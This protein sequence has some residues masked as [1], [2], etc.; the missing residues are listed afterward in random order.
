MKQRQ[1]PEERASARARRT[2]EDAEQQELRRRAKREQW[3]REGMYL[4]RDEFEA[5]EPCRG[6]GQALLD[7]LPELPG[8][9]LGRTPEQQ[10]EWDQE[11]AAFTER[12]PD[13]HA[14]IWSMQGSRTLHCFLCCPPVPLSDEQIEGLRRLVGGPPPHPSSLNVWELSLTC[15]HTSRRRQ[16]RD[17]QRAAWGTD[18]C[19]TCGVVRGVIIAT[20]IGPADEVECGE[21]AARKAQRA[22]KRSD[23]PSKAALRRRLREA[24]AQAEA[25]RVQLAQLDED[26]GPD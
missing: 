10:S 19:A 13:C 16:H 14:G 20:L 7:D 5:G 3:T 4:T 23:Q 1:T 9:E 21:Q 17:M 6:C 11:R 24:E 8:Y 2:A 15:G 26:Q 18:D 25:L 12:H 22:P